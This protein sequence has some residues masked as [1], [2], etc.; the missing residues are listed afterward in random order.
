MEKVSI[1]VQADDDVDLP[2]YASNG[3]SGA[4]VKAKIS[5]NIV[6]EPG[7]SK[8]IPTGLRFEIPEGYEIQVRPRS[9]LAAKEQV[10]VLNTP[11]TIDADY[12]GEL[13]IIMIN[14]GKKLFTVTPGMRI[15]QIVLAP[16]VQAIFQRQEILAATI[17]GEGKFGHT[18][19]H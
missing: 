10:T 9:G 3:A 13:L 15:A 2:F 5:D 4:D 11:G 8:I 19:T 6:I 12:R 14:H 16:V 1:P 18:G 7:E 17:R